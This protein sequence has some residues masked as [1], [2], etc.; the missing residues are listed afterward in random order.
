[1]PSSLRTKMVYNDYFNIDP[2]A[3]AVGTYVFRANS[4]FDPNYTSTGHQPS[5]FDQLSPFYSQYIVL[6]SRIQLR[7]ITQPGSATPAIYGIMLHNSNGL[8][9]DWT[10]I[11]EQPNTHWDNM[12]L[13]VWPS[14]KINHTFKASS[15]Y[16]LKDPST[17]RSQ[18]GAA[19]TTNPADVAYFVVFMQAT[20]LSDDLSSTRFAV[21]IEYDV[22][23]SE[24]D[25]TAQS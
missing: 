19:V 8:A 5:G 18:I 16:G 11:T 9:G 25:Q 23:F 2:S 17:E 22:L 7:A 14:P 24:R 20:N 3:G 15:Y 12:G 13:P 1:M 6:G 21:S 4:I 10:V